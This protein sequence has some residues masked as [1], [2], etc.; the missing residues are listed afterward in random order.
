MLRP[1]RVRKAKFIEYTDATFTTIK[2]RAPEDE[3]MGIMG[4]V[5]RAHVGDTI[6][7]TLRNNGS[8][9]VQHSHA[10]HHPALINVCP[11]YSAT[12]CV[13]VTPTGAAALFPCC[14]TANSHLGGQ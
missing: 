10:P 2:E 1:C 5:L 3:Y 11:L 14:F 13:W 9:Y 8:T 4:P 6:I 12:A 7:V